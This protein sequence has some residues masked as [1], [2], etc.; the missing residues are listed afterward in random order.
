MQ[1]L[2]RRLTGLPKRAVALALGATLVLSIL[3]LL[4]GGVPSAR[5]ADGTRTI[6]GT[7]VLPDE[8]PTTA[9]SGVQLRALADGQAVTEGVPG[10]I[11]ESG[12]YMIS[13]LEPGTYRVVAETQGDA[14]A[15]VA[16]TFHGQSAVLPTGASVDVLAA[17]QSNVDVV[18]T[19]ADGAGARGL[20]GPDADAV[21]Q[22]PAQLTP[23]E[24]TVLSPSVAPAPEASE[25]TGL[26]D[27]DTEDEQLLADLLLRAQTEES[28]SE[29]LQQATAEQ[30]PNDPH[31]QGA[32]D[33]PKPVTS[34]WGGVGEPVYAA[35]AGTT[36]TISGKVTLPAAQTSWLSTMKVFVYDPNVSGNSRLVNVNPTTGAW[37]ATVAPSQ[38]KVQF[39]SEPPA[40]DTR[41]TVTNWFPNAQS[42]S[43]GRYV[44]LRSRNASG[45][46]AS[47]KPG[48]TISGK[49]SLPSGFALNRSRVYALDAS[50]TPVDVYYLGADGTYTFSRLP[51]QPTWFQVVTFD[52][53]YN[54]QMM[55]F[56]RTGGSTKHTLPLGVRSTRN[57][58]GTA[59]KSQIQGRIDV[60]GGLPKDF[61]R[62]ANV[63]QK[64]DGNWF[65]TYY[66]WQNS[67][68]Y[69]GIALAQGEYAV[70]FTAKTGRDVAKGEWWNTQASREAS[71]RITLTG[72]NIA[73]GINGTL[74]TGSSGQVS[75]FVDVKS[76][77]KFYK[78]IAW[79][80]VSKTSTGTKR[81]DGRYYFPKTGVS[82]EAMAAFMYRMNAPANYRAPAKS[83]FID[84]PTSH[85]FYTEIAWMST[86]GLS[87]GVK[88]P[89]GRTYQPT[90]PVS[91][92]AMAAF[93]FRQYAPSSYR[94]PGYS[95]FDDVK[96][97]HK[98]FTEISW[99]YDSGLS[100]GVRSG[101]K[102][103][104][105]GGTVV[106]RE[107]MAAFLYRN[108]LYS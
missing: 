53:Q 9:L 8:V 19:R 66:A 58:A 76:N 6:S 84:V 67:P 54:L 30:N 48:A 98:F 35:A 99:M 59:A 87:T 97:S 74:R 24:A 88:T 105:Q 56:L 36:R 60:A 62:A 91:R 52:A 101:T 80:Y 15:H 16:T 40:Y 37:E 96:T 41:I 104:Y 103:N 82:R 79:M 64:V 38:Y 65:P 57:L 12:E 85:K 46:N 7:V 13:G 39:S 68:E 102:R 20:G 44:D 3:T 23:A 70:E 5:A 95:R 77:H 18:L 94:A 10:S 108:A 29:R 81:S 83:P 73:R 63:F 51:V 22:D 71:T 27:H 11:A 47:V 89:A 75:P 92:E 2:V 31:V 25:P 86:S 49:V 100:T 43:E 21:A 50:A 32:V 72:S 33:G 93:M 14:A 45:I 90:Q 106:T 61:L 42:L 34:V 26:S 1:L 69:T 17:D 55:Q 78:E 28:A 107:A 4:P